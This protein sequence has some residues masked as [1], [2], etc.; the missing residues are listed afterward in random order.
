MIIIELS[1]SIRRW[2]SH[3]DDGR[4]ADTCCGTGHYLGHITSEEECTRAFRAQTTKPGS[5]VVWEPNPSE[6][7]AQP[8]SAPPFGCCLWN[9]P[10]EHDYEHPHRSLCRVSNANA[11]MC[12]PNLERN[13]APA[14]LRALDDHDEA[15][16]NCTNAP[17]SPVTRIANRF[18]C[19]G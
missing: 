13:L 1:C 6:C 14:S 12:R 18:K 5:S 7:P 9:A 19:D 16:F 2:F 3:F 10:P 8:C 17:S 11:F 15:S 4:F